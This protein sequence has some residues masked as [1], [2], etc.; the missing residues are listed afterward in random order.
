MLY[1]GSGSDINRLNLAREAI[2]VWLMNVKTFVMGVG[3]DNF[4][5]FSDYQTY[6][7]STPLELLASNGIVGFSLF[8][9]FLFVLFRKFINLYKYTSD[10]ELKV[11]FFS[12]LI[13]LSIYSF[14]MLA[15]VM[16]DSREIQP[17]LGGLAAFG[18]YHLWLM[19]QGRVNQISA[20][21]SGDAVV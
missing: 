8:M 20:S 6:A 3:Y 13:F 16:Q 10:Q 7:H 15:A 21:V 18:Q 12:T 1:G 5:I 14:F 11:I 19:R 2:H 4:R 9:G 17:I